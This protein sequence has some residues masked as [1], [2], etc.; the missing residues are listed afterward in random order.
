MDSKILKNYSSHTMEYI[1]FNNKKRA[2]VL[3]PLL[4]SDKEPRILFEVRN[5][6]IA[7]GSEICFP[8]GMSE[9]GESGEYT[10][11]R[12]SSE[13][14]LISHDDIEIIA[15]MFE[16]AGPGGIAVSS[17]LGILK[18]YE[19]TWSESEVDHTFSLPVSWFEKHK[20]LTSSAVLKTFPDPDFHFELIEGGKSYPFSE[21]KKDYYFYDTPEGV[22]WGLTAQI[23]YAFIS[24]EGIN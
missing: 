14:L 1:P 2:S 20:P 8:G 6:N 15:P 4:F 21:I 11:I 9:P 5:N 3:I 17:Y 19:N 12:E 10:A 16:M 13:E 23:V 18:N 24:T 7:Q 22:I